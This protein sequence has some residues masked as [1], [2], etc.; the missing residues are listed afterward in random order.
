MLL[1]S[2]P[3]LRP[4]RLSPEVVAVRDRMNFALERKTLITISIAAI[5]HTIDEFCLFHTIS[6]ILNRM[7]GMKL[8]RDVPVVLHGLC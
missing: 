4:G 1:R 8:K 3:F 5:P 7:V 6:L 2:L